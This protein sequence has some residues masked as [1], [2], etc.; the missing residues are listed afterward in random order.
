MAT[1]LEPM[2]KGVRM[3]KTHWPHLKAYFLHRLRNAP[4]E[5]VNSRIPHY[6]QQACGYR[7]RDRFKRDVLFHLGGLDL[8]PEIRP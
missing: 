2:R 4:A 5:G 1:R 7:N 3:L 6:I 8:Y